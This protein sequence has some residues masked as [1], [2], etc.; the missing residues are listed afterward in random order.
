MSP[1]RID[2]SLSPETSVR[3]HLAGGELVIRAARGAGRGRMASQVFAESSVLAL[4]AGVV[5]LFLSWIFLRFSR[6]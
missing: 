6:M 1:T 5:S 3:C 4:T 2:G